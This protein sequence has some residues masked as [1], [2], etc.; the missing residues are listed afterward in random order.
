MLNIFYRTD[1]LYLGKIC[2][3]YYREVPVLPSSEE[4]MTAGK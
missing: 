4:I 1:I 3:T 2:S